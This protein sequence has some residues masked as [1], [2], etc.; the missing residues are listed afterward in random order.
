M[1]VTVGVLLALVTAVTWGSREILLRKAFEKSKPVPGMFLT[2][3][4]TFIISL[5]AALVYESHSW[6]EMTLGV[7][8]LW[9]IVGLLHFPLAMT[10]YYKGIESVGGSRTSVVSNSS[11]LVTPI[12][13]MLLL[14]EPS[15]LHIIVGVFAAGAG[16]ILVSASDPNSSGWRWQRGM[17]FGL[18]AG[19][20]WSI[21]NLLIRFGVTIVALPMTG[22]VVAVGV[23]LIPTALFVFHKNGGGA[24]VSDLRSQRLVIG[25]FLSG[26]GQVTLFA[27]LAVA[28]TVFV[29][30]TY[31]LKSIVTVVLAYLLIPKSEK[32]NLRLILGAVLAVAGIALINI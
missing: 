21:T 2:M 10:L 31:N 1:N 6:S 3:V 19:F 30:P 12:L 27:A 22:L 4:A 13:G 18:L 20:A 23:P 24:T 17:T 5:A 16:I 15:A 11:A 29:V 7:V 9:S 28:A 8:V 26:L 32:I 14:S 25:S